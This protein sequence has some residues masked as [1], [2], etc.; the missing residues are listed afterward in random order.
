MGRLGTA[1]VILVLAVSGVACEVAPDEPT[2]DEEAEPVPSLGVTGEVDSSATPPP[3]PRSRTARVAE[4]LDGDTIRLASGVRVRLVQIDAPESSG[5]CYGEEAGT[6]LRQ[7]LPVGARVRLERDPALDD[8]DRY[9][10]RLRYVFR[11]RTNVNL[12][13][14]R[15]GAASVWFF[16]GDRGRFA[17]ELLAGAR[18]AKAQK[19]GAWGA[20]R[21]RLD[22]SGA[23]ETHPKLAPAPQA[24]AEA[25]A[26]RLCRHLPR[27]LRLGL[28]LHRRR[29]ERARLHRPR[30]RG[31]PRR[32][33]PRPE[34]RRRWLREL[35]V[36]VP[37]LGLDQR[38]DALALRVGT[39]RAVTLREPVDVD[40][41]VVVP[42]LHHRSE[43]VT[44]GTSLRGREP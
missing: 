7:L 20:C 6:A 39:A 27:P 19:R 36:L 5:E 26:I 35:G 10:R 37:A 30:P 2:T 17:R 8:V 12:S 31:R 32:V 21:A 15:S 38:R 42:Q 11:S 28:R 4:V 13:L 34:P 16:N 18:T 1:V 29:R 23:F 3:A 14:V 25:T 33:R 9:D 43:T 40:E 41:A 44:P 24:A 22:P